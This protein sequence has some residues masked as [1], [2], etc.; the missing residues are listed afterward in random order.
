MSLRELIGLLGDRN[1][2][3]ILVSAMDIPRSATYFSVLL[4][5][6]VATSYKCLREMVRDGFLVRSERPLT[7]GGTRVNHYRSRIDRIALTFTGGE[8]SYRML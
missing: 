4:D 3:R 1:K 8:I 6:P 5:I 7:P 2:L